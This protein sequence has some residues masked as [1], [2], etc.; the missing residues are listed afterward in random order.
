MMPRIRT[1]KPELF[2][3]EG[4][5]RAE[6]NHRLPLRLSYIA[7]FTCC[8]R[9]G[10]FRWRPARL[11]LAVLPYDDVDMASVLDALVINGFVKKY[12]F[13][14]EVYG[15]IPS[16]SRHQHINHRESESEIP[17]FDES[18]EIEITKFKVINELPVENPVVND[19]CL[20][21]E[22]RV[23]DASQACPGGKEGKGM[24]RK[25]GEGNDTIVASKT[26]PRSVVDD[27]IHQIFEHWKT[28]MR[29]PHARL[30][31]KRKALI[32]K[33]SKLGYSVEQLCHA[34]TGCSITPHNIGDNERGQ[35]YDGLHVILRDAD[36]IDRFIHHYCCPPK[37]LREVDK[38]QEANLQAL[39]RWMSKKT[40][41]VQHEARV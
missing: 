2:N 41:E 40:E 4:L 29:H 23:L 25:G 21:R 18:K 9:D 19:A 5:F 37:P 3:H 22:S 36:Q 6:V 24:E 16:W 35:R 15:W 12:E 31:P 39:Q 10:R 13:N 14:G 26:R 30:D 38:R 1:V 17:A 20:T 11:K 7:L 28:V 33:A 34:I 32:G 8:D 27:P